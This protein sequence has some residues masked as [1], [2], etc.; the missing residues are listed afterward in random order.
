MK[1][2]KFNNQQGWSMMFNNSLTLENYAQSVL[3][4]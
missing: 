4:A 2:D 3:L 1:P